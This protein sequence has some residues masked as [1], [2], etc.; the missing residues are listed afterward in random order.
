MATDHTALRVRGLRARYD[1][2]D[3]LHGVDLDVAEGEVAVI[4]GPNGA[5]K[6]TMLRAIAGLMP[7]AQGEVFV[8]GRAL[9]GLSTHKR[10][11]AGLGFVP[12]GRGVFG[13]LTVRENLHLNLRGKPDFGAVFE[14][15]PILAER[16]DQRAGELSGGQQQM[17]GIARMVLRD[18][19][20]L[21]IDEP[22]LGLAPT[23]VERVLDALRA[24]SAQGR[25]VLI[26]EQNAAVALAL[27]HTGHVLERG[28]IGMSGPAADLRDDPRVISAYLGG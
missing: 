7:R 20:V 9:S 4:L 17:L 27:A 21:V 10:A 25:T 23:L 22:S 12:E 3:V 28:R 15:F 13:G 16:L 8:R 6:T 24:I 1:G 18:P 2:P 19:A 26:A 14:L 11:A 5:G